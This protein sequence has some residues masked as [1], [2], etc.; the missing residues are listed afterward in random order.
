MALVLV[1]SAAP[2][3]NA[4]V[5]QNSTTASG[6]DF[7][8]VTTYNVPKIGPTDNLKPSTLT[9]KVFTVGCSEGVFEI[10]YYE[11]QF[12]TNDFLY[13]GK[14]TNA[15]MSIDN[16]K[17]FS[18]K[19]KEKPVGNVITVVDPKSLYKKL[20]KSKQ[21][22]ITYKIGGTSWVGVFKTAGLSTHSTS[23]SRYGCNV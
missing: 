22:K 18:L 20:A 8:S 1:L 3:A 11:L 5:P 21:T 16:A 19:V 2:A 7:F 9:A 17:S 13:M 10:L 6:E 15:Q 4:W 23:F 14:A 12:Q